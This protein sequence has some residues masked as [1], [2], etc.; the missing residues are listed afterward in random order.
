MEDSRGDYVFFER[1]KKTNSP[2]KLRRFPS[3][4]SSSPAAA[5]ASHHFLAKSPSTT[6][7]LVGHLN[8]SLR[9]E[10]SYP[11]RRTWGRYTLGL[12]YKLDFLF[13]KETRN[14]VGRAGAGRF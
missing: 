8:G 4:S 12:R 1:E 2:N 9:N 3:S 11:S 5:A 7:F 14:L 6:N 13:C 10:K